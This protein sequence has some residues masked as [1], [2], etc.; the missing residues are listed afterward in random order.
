MR[1]GDEEVRLPAPAAVRWIVGQ[2]EDAGF[3]TW[4]VG[5]AVR[6][7]LRGVRSADWDFATRARPADVRRVFRRTVPI[8]IEHGTVG[9]IARDGVMYEV[10]TFRRDVETDGRHA[11]VAFADRL[12]DDLERRDFTINAVAWHPLSHRLYDPHGGRADLARGVLRTVGEPGMR[13]A[14]DWLRILRALR[15][16]GRFGLLIDPAT[17]N[18]INAGVS[19]LR[20]LSPERVRDELLKI[21]AGPTRPSHALALYE[22]SGALAVLYPELAALDRVDWRKTMTEVDAVRPHRP[23]VRIAAL[24]GRLGT[25]DVSRLPADHPDPPPAG[26]SGSRGVDNTAR[27]AAAR[28]VALLSRLRSSNAQITRVASL[29]LAGVEPPPVAAERDWRHWLSRID[30]EPWRDVVR[31]WLARARAGTLSDQGVRAAIRE[32]RAVVRS[33]PPL[34]VGDLA[35][36]GR[37]LIQLGLR[38]GRHFGTILDQLLDDVLDDPDRNDPEVLRARAL[39]IAHEAARSRTTDE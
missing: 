37:G 32:L 18:A 1:V 26:L 25:L 13:F 29:V 27:R 10:T 35:L 33:H 39:E 14:E 20:Q 8:G 23:W 15:F 3:E 4:A 6:D 24:L 30:V 36:D 34:R 38:P 9:V 5:G 2:L 21:I 31:L 7:E 16:A 12:D 28:A 22:A 19:R 11:V 17:W